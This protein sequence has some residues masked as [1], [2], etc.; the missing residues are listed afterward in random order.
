MY[1][2]IN[3]IIISFFGTINHFVYEWFGRAD[4]FRYFFATDE[5]TFE[6]MK[7]VLYPSLLSMIICMFKYNSFNIIFSSSIGCCVIVVLIPLL[8]YFLKFVFGKS[9]GFVNILIFYIATF[10]GSFVNCYIYYNCYNN[11]NF[12]GI[13]IYFILI[14]LFSYFS[15]YKNNC[16]LFDVPKK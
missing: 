15:V 6:H 4:I 13:I 5:S 10:I 11:Y 2:L 14:V 3:F 12:L 9:I 8:F 16:I 1:L 7:L